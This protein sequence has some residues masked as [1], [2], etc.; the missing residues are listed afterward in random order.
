MSNKILSQGLRREQNHIGPYV[1]LLN[2]IFQ[3]YLF[4]ASLNIT[5]ESHVKWDF[6]IYIYNFWDI[7]LGALSTSYMDLKF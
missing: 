3:Y 7:L 4:I 5:L 6:I 1:G 2:L